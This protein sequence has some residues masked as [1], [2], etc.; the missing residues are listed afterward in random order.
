M[1]SSPSLPFGTYI[2]DSRVPELSEKRIACGL[3]A[4]L[5]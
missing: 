2:P 1:K 4:P 5:R 3:V